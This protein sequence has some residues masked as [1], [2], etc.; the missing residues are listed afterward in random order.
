MLRPIGISC[1]LLL[2]LGACRADPAEL[3]RH[4]GEALRTQVPALQAAY[5]AQ[6]GRYASHMSELN[7][8]TDTLANG[9]LVIIHAGNAATGWAATASHR[10]VPGAAC[11]AFY[12]EPGGR[13]MMRG[14]TEPKVPGLVTC[15]EFARWSKRGEIEADT[16]GW[17]VGTEP[18]RS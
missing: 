7:G 10:D 5:R 17:M 4:A 13:P 15:T 12:G 16:I 14:R 18:P 6:H 8:G 9:T 1:S 2:A 11:A 3:Q